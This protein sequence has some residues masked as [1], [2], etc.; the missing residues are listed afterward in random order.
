MTR[1]D[2]DLPA[3]VSKV[4]AAFEKAHECTDMECTQ[5]W[6]ITSGA[7]AFAELCERFG[8]AEHLDADDDTHAVGEEEPS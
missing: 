1:P 5:C 4:S 6:A 8:L 3:L 2:A 7:A